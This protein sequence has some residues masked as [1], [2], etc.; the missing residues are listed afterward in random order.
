MKDQQQLNYDRIAEVINFIKTHFKSQPS[1]DEMAAHIHMSPYH[2][3]RLFTTWVGTSP[4]N[5]LQYISINHARQ[6]LQ[7]RQAGLAETAWDAGLSGPSRLHDLFIK[8]E[9][10]SPAVY[11]N[12]GNNLNINYSYASSPFGKVIIAFTAKG[13]CYLSFDEDDLSGFHR[14][15]SKYPNATFNHKLDVL[16]QKALSIFNHDWSKMDEIKLHLKASPFQLKVWE[17]LLKIPTGKL[18]TYGSIADQI[19]SP[20][21]ARAVGTAI[22]ANPVAFLIPCHRVIQSS[23]DF[24]GYMWGNTRKR[25]IIGWESV[26]SE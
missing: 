13:I 4:K 5:F 8:L 10:M 2:F 12:G 18:S 21:A 19:G 23:G 7:E 22:G 6:I 9:G 1:L 26:K 20:K 14:L 3:Q 25:A 16:Q 11:R 15:K 24:G 17:C